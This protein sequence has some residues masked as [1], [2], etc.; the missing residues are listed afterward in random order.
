MA[1]EE[2]ESSSPEPGP[3]QATLSSLVKEI[4][5]DM[6]GDE[7]F[8]K[9]DVYDESAEEHW[10]NIDII[11]ERETS[12]GECPPAV[13]PAAS[14]RKPW[15]E[16]Q[17]LHYLLLTDEFG[18][19]E[20]VKEQL[21]AL[22][23]GPPKA[24]SG[25]VAGVSSSG[26]G[27]AAGSNDSSYNSSISVDSGGG[28]S[29][30]IAR[31]LDAY[32]KALLAVP[33]VVQSQVFSGFL[34]EDSRSQRR[35]RST[36]VEGDV[37][38]GR[39]VV[40]SSSAGW[41]ASGSSGWSCGGGGD[42]V[43]KSPETAIDFLLQPFEYGKVYLPRRAEHTDR[44]DVLRGESV[45]WKFEVMDHLD[46]DFSVTFR[47]HPV[48]M[49][50]PTEAAGDGDNNQPAA[51]ETGSAVDP[52]LKQGRL[53]SP[54]PRDAG[55]GASTTTAAKSD[56]SSSSNG[57]EGRR[58]S[59]WWSTSGGAGCKGAAG[60]G[61]GGGEDGGR[62]REEA[63]GGE[64]APK[65]QIVHL[66]TRYSTGGGDP[67]QGSFSCP[68]AGT[69]ILRWDNSFTRLRGKRLCYVFESAT[70]QT[71]R[72]AIEAAGAADHKRRATRSFAA[73]TIL[74]SGHGEV[75]VSVTAVGAGDDFDAADEGEGNETAGGGDNGGGSGSG[76]A[77]GGG[78]VGGV[79]YRSGGGSEGGDGFNNGRAGGGSGM[80]FYGNHYRF[81][82]VRRVVADLLR[83]LG[84]MVD[85]P[86]K[87]GARSS[88]SGADADGGDG[89]GED[90][91]DVSRSGAGNYYRN[92][93]PRAVE[94]LVTQFEILEDELASV[95]AARA[96]SEAQAKV[97]LATLQKAN[98]RADRLERSLEDMR[99]DLST[100][101]LSLSE[102][103]GS[104]DEATAASEVANA[105]LQASEE[106]LLRSRREHDLLQAERSVWQ[107]ARSGIQEELAKVVAEL[108]LERHRHEDTS[109]A[110]AK[111]HESRAHAEA[112][113]ARLSR[114][115]DEE[116]G[117]A[118]GA[119]AALAT[120]REA[121]RLAREEAEDA[122]T[123]VAEL[124]AA[125]A[126]LGAQKRV[127]VAGLRTRERALGDRCA[128]AEARAEEAAM[129]RRAAEA[130]VRELEEEA[131]RR[132]AAQADGEIRLQR[133]RAEKKV[134]LAEVRKGA[135]AGAGTAA[136]ASGGGGVAGGL[137]GNSP[138]GGEKGGGVGVGAR[139]GAGL[140]ALAAGRAG[141]GGGGGSVSS[142]S[143]FSPRSSGENVQ[144]NKA[145]LKQLSK[146]LVHLRERQLHLREDLRADPGNASALRLEGDV[147]RVVQNLETRIRRLLSVVA[148]AGE[149]GEEDDS[150]TGSS[151]SASSMRR[152]RDAS[153]TGNL[154]SL[155]AM[156]APAPGGAAGTAT[157]QA[158][159]SESA[160]ALLGEEETTEV[161]T[162]SVERE[163]ERER[164]RV[165]W[166]HER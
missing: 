6:D 12:G 57:A 20:A 45:V 9:P 156:A 35:R 43:P 38:Q 108:E 42:G 66:P 139:G 137:A 56:G 47:P 62:G 112:E 151:P 153:P 60:T 162:Y 122:R 21:P 93:D 143:S 87:G 107:V 64:R 88:G 155:A 102:T 17:R 36:D 48:A 5:K 29:A 82:R 128:G 80:V 157:A 98:T 4:V 161:Q 18:C 149:R 103:E 58:S 31:G 145:T 118:G 69:C 114:R 50:Q 76:S 124:D 19:D 90:G 91:G 28:S 131:E 109:S 105:R 54:G 55:G 126:E 101:R 25:G 116:R 65:D 83:D 8:S 110:L 37:E 117:G 71:M 166:W 138:A 129:M 106:K 96:Q 78:G 86:G 59:R 53:S 147:D 159:A 130:R 81:G 26:S 70:I 41:R 22:P 148:G 134:L 146:Q 46:I 27:G 63:G 97:L 15:S 163:R 152:K 135:R 115:L 13:S 3:D 141:G 133:L 51:A 68:A 44:I 52:S 1:A 158:T 89:G 160:E 136:A 113:L 125:V 67:V 92:V 111:S 154:G 100:V 49:W 23:A 34:E 79:A 99:D 150:S 7:F 142:R 10:F 144:D 119:R 72:A 24:T 40:S 2:A 33:A 61:A 165:N 95:S 123:A 132:E 77:S 121:A 104:R 94:K 39:R 164:E 30:E 73:Q 11:L 32:L 75:K 84:G 140:E 74:D 14:L 16:F 120:E 85:T 127:L